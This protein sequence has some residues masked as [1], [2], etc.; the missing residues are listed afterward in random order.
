VRLGLG[1]LVLLLA[2]GLEAREV[3][4]AHRDAAGRPK[5]VNALIRERSPYLLDAAH[6]PVKWLPYSE[7]AFEQARAQGK[8]VFVS[9]GYFSC[10]WCH[11][12]ARESFDDL[13]IAAIL[14]RGF[15]ALKMDSEERPDIDR[16]FLA[17]LEALGISPGWPM[18]FVLTPE[19]ELIWGA[20]YIGR[21]ELATTLE[22]LESRWKSDRPRLRRLA[23][24]REQEVRARERPAAPTGSVAQAYDRHVARLVADFDPVHKGF[25][26]GRKFHSPAELGLLLDAHFRGGDGAHG[27]V[28]VDTARAIA[29]GG[30]TDPI[31]GG[32][33][34]Y[35]VAPTW[36][37]PH[38][39][40]MLY[41]QA[42][43]GRLMC[44]AYAIS[45]DPALHRSA[46][47]ILAFGLSAFSTPHGVLA[48]SFDAESEG[49]EGGYYLWSEPELDRLSPPA[50]RLLDASF[51]RAPQASGALLVVP[52]ANAGET[53]P[54]LAEL[55]AL[56][57]TRQAPRRDEKAVTAW[58]ANM[59]AALA[60]CAGVLGDARI[61]ADAAT[62]MRR[63]VATNAPAGH[64]H[65][66][67]IAGTAHGSA[68]LE[69]LGWILA[70]LVALHDADGSREWI[71][72]A[73]A[74][75]ADLATRGEGALTRE[76]ADFARDRTGLSGS[77]VLVQALARLAARTGDAAFEAALDR[78]ASRVRDLAG[79]DGTYSLTAAL[80]D[81]ES[82]APRRQVDAAQGKVRL[83]VARLPGDGPATR[84]VVTADIAP[85]WHINSHRPAQDYLRPT[86][87]SVEGSADA[88]VAYPDGKPLAFGPTGDTLSVLDGSVRFDVH[89]PAARTAPVPPV[90]RI[91]ATIQACTTDVCLR[92]ETV[93]LVGTPAGAGIL[94]RTQGSGRSR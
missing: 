36:M 13:G 25:G 77:A 62:L 19:N 40:R 63:L 49:S 56:R 82:P 38:F 46:T 69:D 74:Q 80:Y 92:P 20:T 31:D 64:A 11:V 28:F 4:S 84:F 55:R 48:G 70:A 32:V 71:D 93:G 21:D 75:A 29:A 17:R 41:D 8:P 10:H 58:N 94:V 86:Q 26:T 53:G 81:I 83:S 3:A 42:Q 6:S 65:R 66:Y 34:R 33:F 27:R 7:A 72:L 76:L 91:K 79:A 47:K 57:A 78:V 67:S 12:M 14:N 43:V 37:Q 89:V 51:R 18:N 87:I 73:K 54:V 16:R 1:A 85:G 52:D 15:V 60:E 24:A 50:R 68:T 9:I 5:F 2:S 59:V 30:L 44:Q 22:R 23:S 90:A 35:S 61:A 88:T 45:A 39:E